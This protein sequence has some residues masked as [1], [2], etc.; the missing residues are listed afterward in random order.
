MSL[1]Q[2]PRLPQHPVPAAK[3][4]SPL[5]PVSPG[6][7]GPG[8]V[9]TPPARLRLGSSAA[10]AVPQPSHGNRLAPTS[11]WCVGPTPGGRDPCPGS[12]GEG[13]SECPW[14]V[15]AAKS[16]LVPSTRTWVVGMQESPSAPPLAL[17][18]KPGLGRGKRGAS[19]ARNGMGSTEGMGGRPFPLD[20]STWWA[21]SAAQ[22]HG[23]DLQAA[24]TAL[25][26]GPWA[27]GRM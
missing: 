2:P 3:P 1:L 11:Q 12:G 27:P 22:G 8:C 21:G 10:P 14:L 5:P 23:P 26:P 20:P 15:T 17:A 16:P 6:W 13:F 4:C 7:K 25:C 9:H 18:P 19:P 24:P